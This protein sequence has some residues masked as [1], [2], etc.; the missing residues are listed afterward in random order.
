[1]KKEHFSLK[2][3]LLSFKYAIQGLCYLF[4]NEH[5]AW[6]HLF[7][8]GCAITAGIFLHISPKEWIV[9]VFAIAIVLVAEAFNTAIE[10][11]SD[12]VSPD[13]HHLVKR[14]KDLA[15]GG[16]LIAAIAAVI[17]GLI[18]FVPKFIALFQS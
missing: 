16:V 9:I 4:K 3:R 1:M 11:L 13:Y 5:N 6:I 10:A 15:A 2:K 14:A 17:A 12:L 8:T 7:V 18:V